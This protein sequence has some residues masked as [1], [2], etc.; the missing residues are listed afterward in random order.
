MAG[1]IPLGK[2]SGQ[3]RAGGASCVREALA[4]GVKVILSLPEGV[5]RYVLFQGLTQIFPATGYSLSW[6]L[7]RFLRRIAPSARGGIGLGSE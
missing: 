4:P 3:G 2:G 1:R 7:R 6:C 5:S